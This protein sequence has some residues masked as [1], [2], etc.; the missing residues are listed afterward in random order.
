MIYYLT[1]GLIAAL[2]TPIFYQ[3]Y[4]SRWETID[5]T[6]A[7]YVLPLSLWLTFRKKVLLKDLWQ[8]SQLQKLDIMGLISII[9]GLMLFIFG[10]RQEYL[11]ISSASLLF[12]LGG[13]IKFLYG[14]LILKALSF[15]LFYLSFLMPP[16]L[17]ILDKITM[18]MR[19][20]IS[21]ASEIILNIFN[22]PVTRSGLL[23]NMDGHE[24]FMGAPCSGLR[25]LVTM[26]ALAVAY[27]YFIKGSFSKKMIL[28]VSVIP[29]ALLGNLIRVLSLCLVT[30]YFGQKTAEGIFH[31]ASGAIIFLIMICCLMG[32]EHLLT[33]TPHNKELRHV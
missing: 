10:W 1:W 4:H 7:Y 31:Y 25:S 20:G 33:K 18:P 15:P 12:V 22:Y 19:Y 6:H 24:I 28:I 17:G 23:L 27:V 9:I 14:N 21:H 2:Y 26:L 3:L 30:F 8:N 32:L 5:Y 29:F 16:P 11:F 13:T